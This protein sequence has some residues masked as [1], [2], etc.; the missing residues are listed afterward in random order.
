MTPRVDSD[1]LLLG[2]LPVE[3]ADEAFE[4]CGPMFGDFFALPDGE[5]GERMIWVIY[6]AIR[7]WNGH[8]DV[9]TRGAAAGPARLGPGALVRRAGLRVK[10]GV[11]DEGRQLGP[12]RRRPRVL[13]DLQ[14][15]A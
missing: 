2:S 12:H 6:E 15:Q 1:F 14:G 4:T 10:D 3:S 5:T 8:P 11:R 7:M 13:R 9:E